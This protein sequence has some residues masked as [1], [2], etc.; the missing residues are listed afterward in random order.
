MQQVQPNETHNN[1]FIE[2]ALGRS[3]GN[4]VLTTRTQGYASLAETKKRFHHHRLVSND[5]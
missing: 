1:N 3:K 2:Q 5:Y 4:P